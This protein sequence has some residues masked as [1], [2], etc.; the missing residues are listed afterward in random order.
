MSTMYLVTYFL[1]NSNIGQKILSSSSSTDDDE[2]CIYDTQRCV[3][4]KHKYKL[5]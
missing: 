5:K 4:H 3:M 1:V 2:V